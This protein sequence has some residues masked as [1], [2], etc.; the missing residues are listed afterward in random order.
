GA[1][2]GLGAGAGASTWIRALIEACRAGFWP[3]PAERIWP[4]MTSDTSP[5]STCARSS[6]ALIAIL[7][8]SWAGRLAS[9]PLNEP[10]GVRAAAA[11]TMGDCS[12]FLK[13]SKKSVDR[14]ALG[15][16]SGQLSG[17]LLGQLLSQLFGR[18]LGQSRGG[19]NKPAQP[20]ST[21]AKSAPPAT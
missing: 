17:Q 20:Q 16:L 8:R 5:G 14:R 4:M 2:G 10:T 11:R 6:A 3:A 21:I 1:Q 9:E 15:Q 19:A 18:L 7:P 13:S 12:C